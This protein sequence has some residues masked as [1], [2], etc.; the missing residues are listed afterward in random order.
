MPLAQPPKEAP[1]TPLHCS[2]L[3]Q[4][5]HI[6]WDSHNYM[7]NV[8]C[9]RGTLCRLVQLYFTSITYS[10][11]LHKSNNAMTTHW[12]VTSWQ[13]HQLK[14]SKVQ[15]YINYSDTINT[16]IRTPTSHQH[17][18]HIPSRMKPHVCTQII[19]K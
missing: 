12:R 14:R 8:S 1:C 6:H 5:K 17:T 3:P 9:T 2:W 19:P 16:I 11:V 7:E 13:A 18:M 15:Q 10:T 4:T